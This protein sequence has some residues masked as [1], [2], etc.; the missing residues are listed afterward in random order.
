MKVSEF[1]KN[2]KRFGKTNGGKFLRADFHIHSPK[3]ADYEYK[4]GDAIERLGQVLREQ[5]YGFAVI[6]EHEKMPDKSLLMELQKHC[7]TT[8][9]LPGAEINIFVDAIFKKVA[10]EYFFHCILIVDPKQDRDYE[11]ILEKTKE[12]FTY[13]D[14]VYPSG[15]T[16][17]IV[18]IGKF[19]IEEGALFIPAHLH[20]SKPPENSRSID[21]IYD[22]TD[23]L[24]FIEDA[25]FS[26]LEVRGITTAAFFIGGK[27]TTNGQI[28][29]AINCV[30]S[31]DAHHHE[32][33]I[34]RNRYTL[35]KSENPSFEELKASLSFRDRVSLVPIAINYSQILG[36]HV[37]GQFIKDEWIALSPSMN[38]LIGCK[39]SGKTSVI[40]CLRF[41]FDTFIPPDRKDNISK[42]LNHILGAS[43]F[44]E[45]LIQ[46]S[47]GSKALLIRR[48]DSP[49]RLRVIESNDMSKDVESLEQIGF[50]ASILGWH[51]IEAV[52]D[53]P[54]SRIN[55]IDRIEIEDD[56]RTLYERIDLKVEFA[57]IV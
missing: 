23:F 33:I 44:V 42:H 38:C 12:K 24:N 19:F 49:K 10:K 35:V 56:I 7:P 20:Q 39:G 9:L 36:V 55:L 1:E 16:S 11:F 43:G 46:R 14:K 32:H 21:D 57:G 34:E 40:E 15:F 13:K 22:D 6:L 31:S 50:E 37:S 51:E 47:D 52:A 3:S 8:F 29:P 27:K 28:I 54:T 53:H 41:V 48:A 18:D 30:R 5:E 26:A 2:L 25:A 17:S 45:C 4:N